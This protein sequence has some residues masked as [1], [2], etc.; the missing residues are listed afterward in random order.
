M[1]APA[2]R[3]CGLASEW[4]SVGGVIA[5][6]SGAD[7]DSMIVRCFMVRQPSGLGEDRALRGRRSGA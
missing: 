2:D 3:S 4:D 1:T 6:K 5:S 7:A